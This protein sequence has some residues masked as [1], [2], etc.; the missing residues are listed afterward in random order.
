MANFAEIKNDIVERVIVI[1]NQVLIDSSG[2][3]NE[4]LGVQF[5]KNLFGQDTEWKQTSYNT[6]NGSHL[7]EGIPLRGNFASPGF[8]YD[9]NVDKFYPPSIHNGWIYSFDLWEWI[10][11]SPMPTSPGL[12][13]WDE[14]EMV[15]AK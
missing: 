10:P 13:Y 5:C 14:E 15:W 12:W 8:I 7:S 3:E 1:D 9:R 6:I 2:N 11:P 4:E